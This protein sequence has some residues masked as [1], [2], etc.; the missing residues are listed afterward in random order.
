MTRP[1][2]ASP[3][4]EIA[5][6]D[7]QMHLLRPTEPGEGVVVKN[8]ICTARKAA[9]FVRH[10]EIDVSGTPLAGA[11]RAGQSFGVI[12]PGEDETGRPHKVRLYS[13]A[14]PTR[15]EDGKGNVLSTTVKRTI[16]EHWDDHRLFLGVASNYLCDL[17]EGDRVKVSGPN[18]K[19]FLLP[20]APGDHDY[21]FF[22]TGTGIAPFRGMLLDLVES[23]VE[24]RIA[25]VMGSPY[26]TDLLYHDFFLRMQEEH[27]NFTYV[28]ALSR[29][30]QTDGKPSMYVQQ[31]MLTERDM[32]LPMLGSERTLIY[33]CGIAGMELGIFQEMARIMT[34]DA[35]EQYLQCDAEALSDISGWNRRMLHKQVKPTRRVFLEVY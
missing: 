26:E 14:A 31:R 30:P 20:S 17:H 27:S 10:V 11:F 1:R 15:G 12:P 21:M 22:A 4:S 6:P 28:T 19:R 35:L 29:Q 23:K 25:L 7:V 32:F 9:G 16:D 18:G 24:S 8:E 5:L 2:A 34:G 3:G 13:I 33:I